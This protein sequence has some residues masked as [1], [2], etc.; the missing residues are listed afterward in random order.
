M[1]Y[2]MQEVLKL[3]PVEIIMEVL[4][5]EEALTGVELTR[6]EAAKAKEVALQLEPGAL[7]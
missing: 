4:G 3:V 6:V 5:G 1:Q 2:L 7:E